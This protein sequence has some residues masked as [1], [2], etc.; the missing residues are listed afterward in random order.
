MTVYFCRYTTQSI[1]DDVWH[2]HVDPQDDVWSAPALP[3]VSRELGTPEWP[4]GQG[5]KSGCPTCQQLE[6]RWRDKESA[7]NSRG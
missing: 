7:A 2:Q 6:R 1:L 3:A 5:L 4:T